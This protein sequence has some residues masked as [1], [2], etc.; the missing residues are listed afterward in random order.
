MENKKRVPQTDWLFQLKQEVPR[1]LERMKGTRTPGFFHYSLSG[2]RFG[3]DKRWGLGNTVFATKIYYTL[4]LLDSLP[5]LDRENMKRFILSFQS[6]DRTIFDPIVAHQAFWRDKLSAIKHRDGQNF[7][8]TQTIRAETRQAVSALK[9]LGHLP[10]VYPDDLPRDPEG[11]VRYL[12]RLDWTRPW[13]AGSH[14]SHLLFFLAQCNLDDKQDLIDVAV[15]WLV[16]LRDA[17]TGCWF[18]GTPTLQ[19]KINGVMKVLTGL[20]A[21]DRMTITEP[22]RLINLALSATNDRHACDHFNVIYVL[23]YAN[24]A[25]GHAYRDGEI[26][27]FALDRLDQYHKHYWPELGGFSYF[28]GKANNIYY[29]AAVSRGLA[30][31]DI[32]GTVMFLWGAALIAQL[33]DI[34]QELGFNEF[35]T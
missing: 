1:F 10:H 27:R 22:E 25:A 4:G 13:G 31:P 2:D 24:E 33:L 8:H 32:H 30:E 15:T 11:V 7:F 9:L 23:K 3:E 6:N 20:K 17:Q 34:D 12:E 19:Q 16:H 21:A 28:L 35:L 14:F 29:N 26:R 18:K 5:S